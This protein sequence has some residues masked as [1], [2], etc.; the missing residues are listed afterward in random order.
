MPLNESLYKKERW[1][2][3]SF[4]RIG[5]AL[6]DVVRNY[7]HEELYP[8]I[9]EVN[10]EGDIVSFRQVMP[11]QQLF[12]NGLSMRSQKPAKFVMHSGGVGCLLGDTVLNEV[13]GRTIKDFCDAN[14]RPM[15]LAMNEE[16]QVVRTLAEVPYIKAVDD[17][18]E[19]TTASGKKITVTA[20]HRFLSDEGWGRLAD[21]PVGSAI[22][23]THPVGVSSQKSLLSSPQTSVYQETT[24]VSSP[25]FQESV[26]VQSEPRSFCGGSHPLAL[27]DDVEHRTSVDGSPVLEPM[28]C[29]R[30]AVSRAFQQI[31]DGLEHS[32]AVD[33]RLR[34]CGFSPLLTI[35]GICP[36]IHPSSA[37]R[38]LSITLDFQDGYRPSCCLCGGQLLSDLGI[39]RECSPSQADVRG[40]I[41]LPLRAG[42]S[43]YGSGYSHAYQQS[44]RPSIR[45][46]QRQVAHHHDAQFQC[47]ASDGICKRFAERLRSSTLYQ[48]PCGFVEPSI[49][50]VRRT[51]QVLPYGEPPD[52]QYTIVRDVV[53]RIE[54]V[55]RDT[56]YDMEVPVYRNY[57]A[58][59]IINKNSGKSLAMWVDLVW[60]LR[61]YPGAKAVIVAGYDYYWDEFIEPTLSLVLDLDEDPFIVKSNRKNKFFKCS[62]GSSF[63][64][65]AYDDPGKVKG[66]DAHWLYFE[67]ASELGDGNSWKAAQIYRSCLMRLRAKPKNIPRFVRVAQNPNGHNWTWKIFVRGN[68][69][70]DIGR[71]TNIA[72]CRNY[73]QRVEDDH[74]KSTKEGHAGQRVYIPTDYDAYRQTI[75]RCC[76]TC[77]LQCK[78]YPNGLSYAEFEKVDTNGDVYYTI[79]SG[80]DANVTLPDGY[81]STMETS[82]ADDPEMLSRMVRGR[83]NPIQSLV[84]Y[85]APYNPSDHVVRMEDV[86]RAY[87]YDRSDHPEIPYWLPTHVGIDVGGPKSPWAVE[88]YRIMTDDIAICT[89]EWYK[90]G[91]TWD[92]VTAAILELVDGLTDVSFWI[93]PYSAPQKQGAAQESVKE[94]FERAGIIVGPAQGCN[95]TAGILHVK[96]ML[97]P[98]RLQPRPYGDDEWDND[99]GGWTH[100]RAR[101]YYIDGAAN[102]NLAEK[103]IW[104]YDTKKLREP[105]ESEEGLS[106]PVQEKPVDRDDHAQRAEHFALAGCFPMP[107]RATREGSSNRKRDSIQG[108]T[109]RI[110]RRV[111]GM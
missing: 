39:C 86:L 13:S 41:R 105:K 67:E 104:R 45:D 38:S 19:V 98:D 64:F 85:G 89:G 108:A 80:S 107:K 47:R 97:K 93:D 66:W 28:P 30:R 32:D 43:D 81:I 76:H 109:Y 82:L 25:L 56:V 50:S 46:G 27:C 60:N 90:A 44:C 29:V 15:V 42:D 63:R 6:D 88:V 3:R 91:V 11:H 73:D 37:A 100:G 12:H 4:D 8:A 110:P 83:F 21:L 24:D 20:A 22:Y 16:G 26:S 65:K 23:V 92:E 77:T 54:Y 95:K 2:Q 33:E 51:G 70:G 57:V 1:R 72:P 52:T 75:K 31:A 102:K 34:L 87:D 62:N 59:T 71:E 99:I 18:Y 55:R 10:E 61:H 49:E 111:R 14:E 36:S 106:A 103:L 53:S 40:R 5:G 94:H 68:P 17:F 84:Y 7:T 35:G 48:R 9:E 58:Q 78:T 101:L 74:V 96:T 79:A 69:D